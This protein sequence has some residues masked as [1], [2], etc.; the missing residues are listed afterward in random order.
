MHDSSNDFFAQ[1]G[2]VDLPLVDRF[3]RVHRSLRISVTD[4]CNI[5][6]QYCMPDGNVPFMPSQRLLSFDQIAQFVKVTAKLGVTH[7]RLTGGEPLMRPDLHELVQ[8]LTGIDGVHEVALTTNGMLLPGQ[9]SSLVRAGL[10]RV[11]I[12]LDTLS[13]ESFQKLSRRAGLHRVLE[14]IQAVLAQPEVELRLNAL[15]LRDINWDDVI[16]L[17][18]FAKQ[19]AVVIRFIEFMPLD[20]RREWSQQRMVSGDELRQRLSTHFGPLTVRPRPDSAQPSTDYLFADGN[21][22]GFI[23]A[24]TRPFCG[25]CDRLRITADGKIRNCL[26]G[27]EEWDVAPQLRELAECEAMGH[28]KADCG[29]DRLKPT[30]LQLQQQLSQVIR[31]CIA[32]KAAAHGVHN[33]DFQPPQRAMYQIGG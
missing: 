32:A 21:A 26:F 20:G 18:S 31:E 7:Y 1:E 23:D 4:V 8:M 30:Y 14:G 25:N 24:V 13:E 12:S 2:S 29:R 27:R 28:C 22:V 3:Q 10:Q 17:V 11:N 5:R 6:C 9:L 16:D 15:V 19:H 33:P